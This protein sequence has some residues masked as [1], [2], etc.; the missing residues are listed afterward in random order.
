MEEKYFMWFDSGRNQV[1]RGPHM[2]FDSQKIGNKYYH[3]L[4]DLL[5]MDISDS[6]KKRLTGAKIGTVVKI[7]YLHSS[8]DLK[9]RRINEDE[10][11]I[12]DELTLSID[13]YTVLQKQLN[14]VDEKIDELNNKLF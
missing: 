11:K 13:E 6:I 14:L 1:Y 8:G 7:Q 5:K 4:E 3:S 12:L 2:W 10:L 9:V